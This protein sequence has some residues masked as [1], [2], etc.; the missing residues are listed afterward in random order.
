[1][2]Y[3]KSTEEDMKTGVGTGVSEVFNINPTKVSGYHGW[4]T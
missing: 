1:M 4:T 2:Y 3:L